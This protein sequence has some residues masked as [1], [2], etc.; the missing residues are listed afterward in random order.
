MKR[1]WL[2]STRTSRSFAAC[3]MKP[4]MGEECLDG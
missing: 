4:A 2:C 1:A 3:Q